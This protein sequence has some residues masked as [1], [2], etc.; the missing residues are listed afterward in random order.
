MEFNENQEK[1]I[2]LRKINL[3]LNYYQNWYLQ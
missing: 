2:N 1:K 3:F